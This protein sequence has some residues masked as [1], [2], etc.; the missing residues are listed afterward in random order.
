[1]RGGYLGDNVKAYVAIGGAPTEG[2]FD[3]YARPGRTGLEHV[4]GPAPRVDYCEERRKMFRWW[5]EYS[6]GK[7]TDWGAHH[8]DIAQWALGH[9][10]SGP[11]KSADKAHSRPWFPTIS[12]WKAFLD[13]EATLPNGFNTAST[14]SIDLKFGDGSLINVND[15][16]R[17]EQDNVDFDNGILFEG[18][19]GR[20]FVNRGKLEGRP[21]DEL[22]AADNEKLDEAILS[23]AKASHR[24]TTCANF[25]ACVEDRQATHFRCQFA[26]QHS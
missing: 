2:P 26:R 14:F 9:E 22:T 16:Y 23:C 25:F 17:R 10:A 19:A 3:N 8:I 24:A 4:A 1:M 6:G 13:G 5:F 15:Y 20:I 7:M 18:D 11:L 21:V 12:D